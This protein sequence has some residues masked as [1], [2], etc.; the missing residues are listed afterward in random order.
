[1]TPATIVKEVM[2]EGVRLAL[3]PTGTIR[4]TGDQA[5]LDRWLPLIRENKPG[6]VAVLQEAANEI[7]KP[8]GVEYTL[9]DLAEMDRLL[10][11]LSKLERWNAG[12]LEQRLD[13]RRR[14]APVNVLEALYALRAARD[15][16]LAGWP[17]NPLER[18]QITLCR[19]VN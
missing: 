5:V 7:H 16:A 15:A 12:E 13:E 6:I 3:T 11:E 18:A 4:A 9:A 1:M 19:F 14:M 17:E 8:E 10:T 2:E